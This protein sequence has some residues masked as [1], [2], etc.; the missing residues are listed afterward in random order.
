M[1]TCSVDGC[2]NK[3]KAKG[4][5]FPHYRQW[6]RYG[7]IPDSTKLRKNKIYNTFF[8]DDHT[9]IIQIYDKNKNPKCQVTIDI[10]D[11][12]KIKNFNWYADGTN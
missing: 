11:Y 7:E 9:C 2:N 4:F 5:C 6:E 12:E 10:E 1:R 8:I 3:H